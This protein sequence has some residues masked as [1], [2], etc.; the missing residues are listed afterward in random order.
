M[1]YG[2]VVRREFRID[3]QYHCRFESNEFHLELVSIGGSGGGATDGL[4][5]FVRFPQWYVLWR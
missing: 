1:G 2:S 4:L 3:C 5:W